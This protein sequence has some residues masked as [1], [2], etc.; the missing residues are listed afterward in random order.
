MDIRPRPGQV[1]QIHHHAQASQPGGSVNWGWRLA[2]TS[3]ALACLVVL[4]VAIAQRLRT[5][6]ERTRPD[7]SLVA[8]TSPAGPSKVV[9]A[10]TARPEPSQSM[11]TPKPSPVRSP[12]V[13]GNT[14]AELLPKLITPRDG[15]VLQRDDLEFRWEPVSD[16]IS[17][18]VRVMSVTGDV[19]FEG[20]TDG[21][22]LKP[23]SSAQLVPG[24]KY[25]VLTRAHL[26]QGKTAKSSIV[27]FRL[28][29]H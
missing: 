21:T 1:R 9:P 16:A 25:F 6:N 15:A 4:I 17:Y 13:R 5:A 14:A 7:N 2:V 11:R 20:Q 26:P 10:P 27:S 18:D 23:D 29:G 22:S 24:T 19:V 3:A 8:Q 12:A 28:A